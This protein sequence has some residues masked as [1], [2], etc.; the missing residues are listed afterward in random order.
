MG[1]QV[2][3]RELRQ[4]GVAIRRA[5]RGAQPVARQREALPA[6]THGAEHHLAAGG[7]ER[8][9][10]RQDLALDPDPRGGQPLAQRAARERPFR[11]ERAHDDRLRGLR[12]AAQ[13]REPAAV[14]RRA[15]RRRERVQPRVVVRRDEVQRAAHQP[16]GDERAV[17]RER[18]VD[19]GRRARGAAGAQGEA[20][21]PQVLRLH[22]EQAR[23]RAGRI[24]RRR[25]GEQLRRR[26]PPAQLRRAHSATR[27]R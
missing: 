5:L 15:E 2:A 26:A 11:G 24:E 4:R 17:V 20:R 13:L 6:V 27:M 19:R 1:A 23:H 9:Q 8:E 21:H 25:A 14:G 10:V 16:A 12:V 18:S 3:A 22:R 7:G